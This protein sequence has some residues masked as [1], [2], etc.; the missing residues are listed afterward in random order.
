MISQQLLDF[1]RCPL[2]PSH[3]R[4]EQ[5]PEGFLCQRCRLKF[6]VRDGIPC[7]LPE[8]AELPPGCHSLADLPC[9]KGPT[10][11]PQP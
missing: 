7:M 5:V 8:E 1:L 9:Q 11:E 3:T 2:D 10:P 6:P 4:L